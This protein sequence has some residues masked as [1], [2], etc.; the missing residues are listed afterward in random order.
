MVASGQEV[1]SESAR[2]AERRETDTPASEHQT[3]HGEHSAEHADN[4]LKR[5]EDALPDGTAQTEHGHEVNPSPE[6]QLKAD[7]DHSLDDTPYTEDETKHFR[8]A[9]RDWTAQ[10][11]TPEGSGELLPTGEE[12]VEMKDEKASRFEAF[13]QE[14]EKPETLDNLHDVVE[15]KANTIQQW[16]EKEPP[17]SHAE[18]SVPTNYPHME[19]TPHDLEAG[20]IATM[21]L[22][23]G[24]VAF[25]LG[26]R[27]KKT[28]DG[29]R[30]R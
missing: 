9:G 22:A 28:I 3:S 12:L 23:L 1:V 16:L 13:R 14:V 10:A 26:R 2:Q 6:D 20:S 17:A 18:Q 8:A 29:W 30:G 5:P 7:P 15:Q 24:I 4:S 11:Q 25:E 19:A 27:G 21:G